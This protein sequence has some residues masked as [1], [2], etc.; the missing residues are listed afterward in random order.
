MVVLIP[1]A[2]EYIL[3]GLG[4]G[5]VGHETLPG[6]KEREDSVKSLGNAITG[7]GQSA[8]SDMDAAKSGA[9][10]NAVPGNAVGVCS[11]C[12]PPDS[13]CRFDKY[14]DLKCSG[15]GE[16]KH[17]II[18]DYVLRA[19]K[20]L[21]STLR[22]PNAPSLNDGPSICLDAD[23]HKAVHKAMDSAIKDLGPDG[24]L[25]QVKDIALKAIEQVKKDCKGK[26]DGL[27]SQVDKAFE[28]M[29]DD[30]PVR[31]KK[32]PLP[33][34]DLLDKLFGGTKGGMR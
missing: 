5:I 30:A 2:I 21:D 3:I 4:V 1:P 6:K 15:D 20:R 13:G 10:A 33:S 31:T 12:P 27:K 14:K 9:E 28:E 25:G 16:D 24:T 26:M 22:L 19:G 23:E 8:A 32:S 17:H 18:A 7:N 11:T 29:G 34:G